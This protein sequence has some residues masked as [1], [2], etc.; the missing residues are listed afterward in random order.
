MLT[1]RRVVE[2][3]RYRVPT[4]RDTFVCADKAVIVNLLTTLEEAI[5]VAIDMLTNDG[6]L[7][8]PGRLGLTTRPAMTTA[9][10]M[11]TAGGLAMLGMLTVHE[12]DGITFY[13][14]AAEGR[15]Y[16]T[17]IYARGT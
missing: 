12:D 4:T 10:V 5:L 17:S 6:E 1:P 2:Q 7:P 13:A 9:E 3:S 8:A 15:E 16:L 14:L 11:R